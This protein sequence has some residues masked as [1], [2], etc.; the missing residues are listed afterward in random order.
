[1]IRGKIVS[2][3]NVISKNRPA[4][5]EVEELYRGKLIFE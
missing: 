2:L 5:V 4:I 1:A 3:G